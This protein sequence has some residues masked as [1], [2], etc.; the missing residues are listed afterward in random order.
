MA[1][2]ILTVK[3]WHKRLSVILKGLRANAT[4]LQKESKG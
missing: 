3:Q 4:K 2:K 1:N